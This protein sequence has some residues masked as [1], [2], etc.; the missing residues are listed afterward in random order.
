[1]NERDRLKDVE[2]DENINIPRLARQLFA[3]RPGATTLL[4]PRPPAVKNALDY[5]TADQRAV[6]AGAGTH[7]HRLRAKDGILF[8]PSLEI[9]VDAGDGAL[10]QDLEGAVLECLAS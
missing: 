1:M 5:A 8:P 3:L 6:V 10:H 4:V 2:K 7:L 9:Q